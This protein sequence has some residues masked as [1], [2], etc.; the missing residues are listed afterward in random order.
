MNSFVSPE[1]APDSLFKLSRQ[2]A[3][4]AFSKK[5]KLVILSPISTISNTARVLQYKTNKRA[6]IS[7][8]SHGYELPELKGCHQALPELTVATLLRLQRDGGATL[9]AGT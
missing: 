3:M 8:S 1:Y 4:N 9:Y 5:A 7:S 6:V 2:S